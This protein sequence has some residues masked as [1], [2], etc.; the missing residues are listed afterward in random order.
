[1]YITVQQLVDEIR[2]ISGLRANPLYSDQDIADLASDCWQELYDKFVAANQHYNVSTFDFTLTGGGVAGLGVNQVELPSDFQ[3]GNGLELYPETPRPWSVPY[4]ENWLNRNSLGLTALNVQI[5]T[6]ADRRY[7]F[8]GDR[9]IVFPPTSA[10]GPY[11]LYYTPQAEGLAI[12]VTTDFDVEPGDV[13]VNGG[14]FTVLSL[15]GYL[16]GFND[17]DIGKTIDVTFDSPNA[18]FNT[19]GTITEVQD[20]NSIVTSQAWPGGTFTGPAAGT[21]SLSGIPAGTVSVMPRQAQPWKI[22]VTLW[23]A[24][25][26]RQAREQECSDLERRMAHQ[27]QRVDMMLTNRQEEATQPPLTRNQGYWDWY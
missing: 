26:I 11:R 7:C 4:L 13:A 6:I 15:D 1:M 17:S 18:A 10:Q 23:T 20:S 8:N 16:P 3:L 14:G 12:P 9:L 19:H 22:Y 25:A 2:L 24:I 5:P 27:E 21:A